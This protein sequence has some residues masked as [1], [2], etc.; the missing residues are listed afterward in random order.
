MS[1][2]VLNYSTFQRLYGG[3]LVILDEI[4]VNQKIS[5]YVK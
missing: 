4:L 1:S 2:P 3:Y 5:G